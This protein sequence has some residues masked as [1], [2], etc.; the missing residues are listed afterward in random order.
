MTD[1][2]K[3]E[4]MKLAMQDNRCGILCAACDLLCARLCPS[5]IFPA[6]IDP[7]WCTIDMCEKCWNEA[8]DR[9]I[10]KIAP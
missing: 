1:N 3:I 10:K 9:N 5:D 2:Q 6:E 4:I 8:A 7:K